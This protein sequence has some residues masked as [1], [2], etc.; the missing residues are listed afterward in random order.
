MKIGDII[1]RNGLE[2]VITDI[3]DSKYRIKISVWGA[4]IYKWV[5]IEEIR[6]HSWL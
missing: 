3:F 5:P 4:S 6:L 2:G 1:T